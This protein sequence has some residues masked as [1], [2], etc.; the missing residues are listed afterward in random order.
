MQFGAG[1]IFWVR[2]TLLLMNFMNRKHLILLFVL[3]FIVSCASIVSRSS[4]PYY[5]ESDPANATITI[6]NKKGREIFKGKTPTVVRLKSGSGYFG[7]ESYVIRYSKPGYEEK[8][9]NV[10]CKLNGWYLGNL[11]IG[12]AIGLLIVD[13][14]TGAMYRVEGKGTRTTLNPTEAAHTRTL[15]I[16]DLNKI[17][18]DWHS[19]LVAIK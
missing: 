16:V 4:W 11:L 1:M 9:V 5:V 7:K 3:P 10:E 19:K 17:P 14:A 8:K 2:K 6:E 15:K 12:G 18:A 13:P